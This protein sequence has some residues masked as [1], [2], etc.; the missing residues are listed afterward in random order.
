MGG[1]SELGSWEY[2]DGFYGQARLDRL[3]KRA[4]EENLP[5]AFDLETTGLDPFFNDILLVSFTLDGVNGFVFSPNSLDVSGFLKVLSSVPV[6]GHNI[7]FDYKFIKC[8]YDVEINIFWDTQ[9]VFNL[10]TAGITRELGGA[11]LKNLTKFFLGVELQKELRKDFTKADFELSEDLVKYAALDALAT[12]QLVP[13]TEQAL[14]LSDMENLWEQI[15]R[16][17]IKVLAEMELRGAPVDRDLALSL[18]SE[19]RTKMDEI[20]KE[21]ETSTL[22]DEVSEAVCPDCRNR[23][24]KK[25]TCSTCG[26]QGHIRQTVRVGVNPNSPSQLIR[27]FE[28]VGVQVP[29]VD[30]KS[31]KSSLSVDDTSLAKINHPLASKVREYRGYAKAVSAFL[32]PWSSAIGTAE[33]KF[34]HRTGCIHPEITQ[35]DTYTGR[36]SMRNPNLQQVPESFRKIFRASP[37]YKIITMDYSQM[38]IR[39]LAQISQDPELL[40]IFKKREQLKD[41]GDEEQLAQLDTHSLIALKL[42]RLDPSEVDFNSKEWKDKRKKSKMVNFAILYGSGPRN[43]SES[44]GTSLQETKDLIES[45]FGQFRGVRAYVE[46]TQK[47]V[48]MTDEKELREFLGLH[49]CRLCYSMSLGGRKRYYILPDYYSSNG[50]FS[51]IYASIQRKSVNQ[52]I[53]ST[54]ADISKL[55]MVRLYEEYKKEKYR[56]EVAIRLMVHDELDTS[57][58]EDLAEEVAKV[59]EKVMLDCA[60][61]YLPDVPCE[62]GVVIDD[63]W[64]K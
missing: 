45:Y 2:L 40:E 47:Q 5:I 46:K 56:G 61:V 51:A 39:I 54:N 7:K 30:R 53:Q 3:V 9:V 6:I 25:L 18:Y 22:H 37:G 24:L 33:G 27:Y 60:R 63:C 23:G 14:K 31:G 4:I 55:A 48:S 50:N 58:P 10:A 44:L 52:R 41:S 62:V 20:A 42:F 35:V 64:S 12:Y 29:V 34:N 49:G 13:F 43:L 21:I 1:L 57:A 36:T 17:L 15:E 32:I 59:Q 38:E 8:K 28:S 19:Y 26:G 16:P 11:G